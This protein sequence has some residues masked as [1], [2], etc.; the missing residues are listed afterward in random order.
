MRKFSKNHVYQFNNVVRE[1]ITDK[2]LDSFFKVISTI[3]KL[4]A[5]KEIYEAVNQDK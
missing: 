5:D 2:E 4:I 1:Y 3:N